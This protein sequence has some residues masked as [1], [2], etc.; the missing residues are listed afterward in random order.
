MS[1]RNVRFLRSHAGVDPRMI[2]VDLRSRGRRR[3]DDTQDPDGRAVARAN[4]M[5]GAWWRA[6]VGRFLRLSPV[7]Q[8]ALSGLLATLLIALG[9]VTEIRH[10]A[11]RQAI[12]DAKHTTSLAGRGIVEPTLQRA[13]LRGDRAA[14]D[15]L[16]HLVRTRIRRD[17]IV[18]VK[19]WSADGRV[20]YSDER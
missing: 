10:T 18:R 5:S 7:A 15:R 13:L 6:P 19:L 3:A 4:R 17:G 1:Q 20:I 11:T 8:F 12:D 2:P 14:I 9:A 16:D